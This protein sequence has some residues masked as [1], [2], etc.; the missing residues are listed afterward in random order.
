MDLMKKKKIK[1]KKT[2]SPMK[3]FFC[4]VRKC[5]RLIF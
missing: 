2:F 5:C 4:L 3:P 1:K